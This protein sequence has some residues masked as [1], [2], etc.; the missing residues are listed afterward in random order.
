MKTVLYIEDGDDILLPKKYHKINNICAIIYDQLTEIYNE[1]SYNELKHTS[2]KFT[3][4]S[5]LVEELKANKI[6]ALD[7]LKQ[8]NLNNEIT[9][10]LTKHLISAI[11]HDFLNFMFESLN[12]AK[13][14]KMTVAYALLRKPITDELLILEQLLVDKTEFIDRFFHIAIPDNYDPSSKQINK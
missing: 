8:N 6:H 9:S 2:F 5:V 7:W 12:C 14:G 10:V 1:Y 4:N 13:K 11:V 3:A